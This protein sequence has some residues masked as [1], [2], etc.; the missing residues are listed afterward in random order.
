[1][2]NTA[3]H[4]IY[5]TADMWTAANTFIGDLIKQIMGML[6]GVFVLF[7]IVSVLFMMISNNDRSVGTAKSWVIRVVICYVI[8]MGVGSIASYLKGKL[9]TYNYTVSMIRPAIQM[10]YTPSTTNKLVITFPDS[11]G[12]V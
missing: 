9:A 10:K 4:G 1:V 3:I 12:K 8:I 2:L 7:L 11:S 6:T 5:L